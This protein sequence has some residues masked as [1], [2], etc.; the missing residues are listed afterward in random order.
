MESEGG[1]VKS[2]IDQIR[3]AAAFNEKECWNEWSTHTDTPPYSVFY[4]G[5]KHQHAQNAWAFEA[6]EIAV[7]HL[8]NE[9]RRMDCA[10]DKKVLR[11]IAALVPGGES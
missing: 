1:N 2:L 9:V 11:E 4:C 7:K 5:A 6:L 8:E 3:N 10:L